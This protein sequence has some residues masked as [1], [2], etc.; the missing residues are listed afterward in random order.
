MIAEKANE[1]AA[2]GDDDAGD[3]N[4]DDAGG[5]ANKEA[6]DPDAENKPKKLAEP[7]KI[8]LTLVED[9]KAKASCCIMTEAGKQY[10][11][12][13]HI[14]KIIGEALGVNSSAVKLMQKSKETVKYFLNDSDRAPNTMHVMGVKSLPKGVLLNKSQA[15]ALQHDFYTLYGD[16]KFQADLQ[17]LLTGTSGKERALGMQEL[18]FGVQIQVLK[19]YGFEETRQGANCMTSFFVMCYLNDE[20]IQAMNSK[21]NNLL[22]APAD[23][24]ATSS[25]METIDDSVSLSDSRKIV[26]SIGNKEKAGS[27]I[28]FTDAGSE[29]QTVER[30]RKH[31]SEACGKQYSDIKLTRNTGTSITPLED[32]D[33]VPTSIVVQGLE[34]LPKPV[35]LTKN[36]TLALQRDMYSRYI[37]EEFQAARRE[38]FEAIVGSDRTKAFSELTFA[39]QKHVL[40]KYGYEE[41]PRAAIE[42]TMFFMNCYTNDPDIQE[43]NWRL[44]ALLGV[45]TPAMPT[46]PNVWIVPTSDKGSIMVR[47]GKDLTSPEAGRLETHA[48]LSELQ[49]DGERLQY[50]KICGEG[51]ASGWVSLKVRGKPMVNPL[52]RQ[53]GPV[54]F[55]QSEKGILVRESKDLTSPELG[56]LMNGCMVEQLSLQGNRLHYQKLVGQ[57]EGPETGWVSITVNGNFVM[58]CKRI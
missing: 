46:Q 40:P 32:T 8:E 49:L 22:A 41:A 18:L 34:R 55:I 6:G 1:S 50:H 25:D 10:Q 21:I 23:G 5:K 14:R 56:R 19:K 7:R 54:W 53:L 2:E 35:L 28:L 30:I 51:P 3:R 26:I 58:K 29:N 27:C 43:M 37:T 17:Q 44:N 42:S 31:I 38:L 36:Q 24:P 15:L 4:H 45:P 57:T 39:E 52:G 16:A 47:E 20:Q 48:Y 13:G 9:A 33:R 11:L 12:V